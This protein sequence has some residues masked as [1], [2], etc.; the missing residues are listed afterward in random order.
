MPHCRSRQTSTGK[1]LSRAYRQTRTAITLR[2]CQVSTG[3]C[4]GWKVQDMHARRMTTCDPSLYGFKK[5]VSWKKHVNECF[6]SYSDRLGKTNAIA[7]PDPQCAITYESDQQLWYHL[8]D[9]H[10]YPSRNDR[11]RTKKKRNVFVDGGYAPYQRKRYCTR[12][13]EE[14]ANSEVASVADVKPAVDSY[15]PIPT[16]STSYGRDLDGTTSPSTRHCP[17]VGLRRRN[18]SKGLSIIYFGLVAV[19]WLC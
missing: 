15:W 18:S 8:Q 9:V 12:V 4:F 5:Q 2:F 6:A 14:A 19:S 10:S 1:S 13:A 11:P 7:C 17:L 16:A 3:H